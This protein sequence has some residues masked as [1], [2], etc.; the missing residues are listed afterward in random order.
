[1]VGPVLVP[2]FSL[3]GGWRSI[4]RHLA[5]AYFGAVLPGRRRGLMWTLCASQWLFAGGE[6]R[7]LD[8]VGPTFENAY[9]WIG[10]V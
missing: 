6:S 3:G 1:M 4:R 10:V 8:W 5:I 2:S 7:S 9:L